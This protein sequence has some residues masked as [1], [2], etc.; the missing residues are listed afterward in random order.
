MADLRMRLSGR[1]YSASEIAELAQCTSVQLGY[2]EEIQLLPPRERSSAREYDDLDL[3]RLQQI[4][5]GRAWGLALEETRRW[6]A[7]CV[8]PFPAEPFRAD[9]SRTPVMRPRGAP[10][11]IEIEVKAETESDRCEFQR[12]ADGLYDALSARWRSGSSPQDKRLAR[13]VE[14]HRCHIERWFCPCE[15]RRHAAFA[16]AILHNPCLAASIARHGKHL[17]TFLLGVIEAHSP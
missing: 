8:D 6:L 5:I 4:R 13:W 2:Y 15:A 11:Y 12:E 3:L 14:R 9:P 7:H 17:G 16:R 10:L 1:T